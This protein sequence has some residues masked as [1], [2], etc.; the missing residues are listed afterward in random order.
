MSRSSKRLYQSLWVIGVL[1]SAI[2]GVMLLAARYGPHAWG[3][4]SN[5][6]K[7]RVLTSI[8]D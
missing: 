2:G 1:A 4:L 8:R 5:D 6:L 7:T 3:D